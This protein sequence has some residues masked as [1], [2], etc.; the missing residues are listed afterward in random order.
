[1][2]KIWDK[3]LDKTINPI[4]IYYRVFKKKKSLEHGAITG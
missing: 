2:I 3:S 1:M 4:E